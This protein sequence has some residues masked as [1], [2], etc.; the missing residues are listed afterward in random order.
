MN[1]V[2]CKKQLVKGSQLKTVV[3][4]FVSICTK[5]FQADKYNPI[6]V[7]EWTTKEQQRAIEIAYEKGVEKGAKLRRER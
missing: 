6:V 1:C 2:I 7:F 5:C 3:R 4:S